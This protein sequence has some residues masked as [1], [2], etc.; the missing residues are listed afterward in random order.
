[1]MKMNEKMR[2]IDIFIFIFID[3]IEA[4]SF[5]FMTSRVCFYRYFSA[6]LTLI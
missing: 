6:S 3:F 2:Y 5:F 1:M 4:H